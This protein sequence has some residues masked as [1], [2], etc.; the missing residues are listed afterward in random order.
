MNSI[1]YSP[2]ALGDLDEIWEYIAIKLSD[3]VA[4]DNTI[5]GILN[6]VDQLERFSEIGTPLYF[7]SGLFSGYRFVIYNNYL[8]FY[9][10]VG[11]SVYIDRVI[12]VK[13]DYMHILFGN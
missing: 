8:A 11:N 9:R 4:A 13:R 12:Y 6:A 1:N 7:E 3:R 5:D 10:I 2:K